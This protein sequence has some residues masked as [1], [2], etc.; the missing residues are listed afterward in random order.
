MARVPENELLDISP[1]GLAL[2]KKW[3]GWYPKAYKDPVGVWTIGWGT[4][5]AEARPGRTITKKQG[6]EYLRR[7]LDEAERYV[8]H[9]VKVPLTQHQFD[10]LV[11]L[12]FNIGVGNFSRSTLLKL[13]NR[14]NFIGASGQFTRY[15]TA[16]DRETG[17]RIVLKGLTNRRRDEALLF[18]LP[19][20]EDPPWDLDMEK[21]AALENPQDFDGDIQPDGP[22]TNKDAMRE[23]VEE[24][25]TFKALLA[26]ITG[27]I[28][29]V[30]QLLEPIRD[31]PMLGIA[32]LTILAGA[33]ATFYIKY[34]D[35]S[36]GR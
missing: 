1:A 32:L 19:D 27:L 9:Y 18:T 36:E 35:T 7:D 21:Q 8:K 4:T 13:V 15:N 3:E 12:V 25:D 24:S 28:A 34:R 11:S 10:A 33:G 31:N 26:T 29:A 5:G 22:S 16:R 23:V 14:R 6:E 20:D 30:T 2:I 17:K